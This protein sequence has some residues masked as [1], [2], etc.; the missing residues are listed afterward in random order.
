MPYITPDRKDRIDISVGPVE[1][2]GDL[3]YV[4]Y[5]IARSYGAAADQSY[6]RHAEVIA[7]LDNAK[8][9]YRRRYLNPYEDQKR[10]DNGDV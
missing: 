4:L 8:E 9:E 5:F 1:N 6:A 7:G 10:R 3:T 2:V